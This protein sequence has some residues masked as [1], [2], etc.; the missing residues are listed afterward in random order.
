MVGG[1]YQAFVVDVRIA[2]KGGGILGRLNRNAVDSPGD[3]ADVMR[4]SEQVSQ[5]S[6]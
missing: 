5:C 4:H 6:R 1:S 2:R 3:A